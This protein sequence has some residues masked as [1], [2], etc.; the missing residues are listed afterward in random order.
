M[1]IQSV[2]AIS[3]LEVTPEADLGLKIRVKGLVNSGGWSNPTL[4]RRENVREDGVVEFDFLADAPTGI[5]TQSFV[6]IS[7]K[8]MEDISETTKI[9]RVIASTNQMEFTVPSDN[10]IQIQGGWRGFQGRIKGR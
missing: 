1:S 4:A 9:I 5:V 6:V 3:S 10:D 7:I 2:Y 8:A